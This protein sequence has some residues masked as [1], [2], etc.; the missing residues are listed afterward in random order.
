MMDM[1]NFFSFRMGMVLFAALLLFGP[2]AQTVTAADVLVVGVS[3]DIPPMVFRDR[4]VELIGYD[5]DLLNEIG[6]RINKKIEFKVISWDQKEQELANQ[7]IDV[8]AS[9]LSITE[10]RKKILRYTQPVMQNFQ[11]I[12]VAAASPIQNKK[13]LEG[14][15]VCTL[16]GAFVIDKIH[17]LPGQKIQVKTA[18]GNE[19]CLVK[20][21]AGE[22]DA[23]VLDGVPDS[24]DRKSVV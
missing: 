22:V 19:Q 3:D 24:L 12:I 20:L 10:E 21:L 8:I 7:S 18:D 1:K 13:D 15:S 23:S 2:G 5:V 9:Q 16:A 14:K 11:A 4:G 6:R 17:K